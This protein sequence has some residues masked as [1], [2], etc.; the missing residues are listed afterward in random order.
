MTN[1]CV[2][3]PKTGIGERL[4]RIRMKRI[5]WIILGCLLL[6]TG[7]AASFDCARATSTIEQLICNDFQLSKIDEDLAAAYARALKETNNPESVRKQQ[8]EWLGKLRKSCADVACVK[9]AYLE[10]IT[11]LDS[12]KKTEASFAPHAIKTDSEVCQLIA[13]HANRKNLDVDSAQV[14]PTALELD[15]LKLIFGN[16][17]EDYATM[18]YYWHVDLDGDGIP[19]DFVVQVEGTMRS[20]TGYALS[21]RKGATIAILSDFEDGN[22]DIWLKTV[23]GNNYL[24]SSHEGRLGKLWRLAESGE[25]E[26]VCSF[27]QRSEPVVELIEG[28]GNKVCSEVN[29]DHILHAKYS[30]QHQIDTESSRISYWATRAKEGLTRVDIDNDGRLDNVVQI[31]NTHGAGRGCRA[32]YIAV[33][34]EK[35][36]DIPDTKI[37]K[38]LLDELGGWCGPNSDVFTYANEVYVD[39]Q[40]DAGNR[41]IY[42][43]KG[44]KTEIV[45]EFEGQLITDVAN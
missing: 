27:T 42:L 18:P 34:N 6:T 36:T 7:H 12:I 29:Q 13:D 37:N 25:F 19:D 45:C 43:I 44:G 38:F 32:T 2:V 16:N 39:A 31:D 8:R 17:I 10:R 11:K 40:A 5:A 1:N 4:L 20:S 21:G 41:K 28:K 15:Q 9:S 14:A 3:L 23:A 26:V 33:T 24:L 35:R 30:L 22:I